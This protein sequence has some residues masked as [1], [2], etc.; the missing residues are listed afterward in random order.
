MNDDVA[1]YVAT[2]AWLDCLGFAIG[3]GYALIVT[4]KWSAFRVLPVLGLCWLCVGLMLAT[5]VA[6][7]V[8]D[9]SANAHPVKQERWPMCDPTL[10]IVT[11]GLFAVWKSFGFGKRKN[12]GAD[13][14]RIRGMS[15]DELHDAPNAALIAEEQRLHGVYLDSFC[16]NKVCRARIDE[17]RRAIDWQEVG[18]ERPVATRPAPR[19]EKT[20]TPLTRVST[21][22]V[23]A[24]PK[25]VTRHG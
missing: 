17:V 22:L 1:A 10:A 24:S 2:V 23:L 15:A 9:T 11:G 13:A 4:H 6:A 18:G 14:A 8:D 16:T 19:V 7:L 3:T 5:A 21:A 12:P 20:P 25:G